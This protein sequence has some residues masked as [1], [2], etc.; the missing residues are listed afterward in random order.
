M[1]YKETVNTDKESKEDK[2]SNQWRFKRHRLKA[3]M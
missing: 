3:D 2:D 1:Q